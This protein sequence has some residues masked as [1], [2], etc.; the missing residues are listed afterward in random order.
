[1]GPIRN[2][3]ATFTGNSYI[4]TPLDSKGRNYTLSFSVFPTSDIPGTL[5]AGSQS[6]LVAGNGTITNITMISF[7]SPYSLNYTLPLNVWTDVSLFSN[8]SS[9][10]LKTKTEGKKEA[11][12]E[13]LTRLGSN[14]VKTYWREIAFEAPLKK[15]GEGFRGQIKDITLTGSA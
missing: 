8:G 10:Y 9:T 7:G 3:A 5:F 12:M 11:V 15:I 1:M 2:S 6:T 13:F 14:G 4:T